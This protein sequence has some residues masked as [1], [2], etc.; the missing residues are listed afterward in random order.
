M[1]GSM[2]RQT[3]SSLYLR[4]SCYITTAMK[5]NRKQRGEGRKTSLANEVKKRRQIDVGVESSSY[6]MGCDLNLG[7]PRSTDCLSAAFELHGLANEVI[8]F[9]PGNPPNFSHHGK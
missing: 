8:N 5:Q 4:L 9:R 1:Q 3:S 2:K 6:K 7:T